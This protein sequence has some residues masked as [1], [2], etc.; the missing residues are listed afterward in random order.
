[1]VLWNAANPGNVIIWKEV[2]ATARTP[3]VTLQSREVRRTDDFERVFA[4]ITK[5]RPEGRADQVIQ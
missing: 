5:E 1:V 3:G 2:Q 4:A